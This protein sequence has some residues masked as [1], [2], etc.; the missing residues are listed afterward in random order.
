MN[1]I[2]S[3]IAAATAA[4][5][6][7]AA[8]Y[9]TA[10]A[11][12]TSQENAKTSDSARRTP[13]VRAVERIGPAVVNVHTETIVETPF[14]G[15]PGPTGDPFFDRFFHGFSPQPRA[16]KRTSLGSGV[17]VGK[18]GTLVTNEHVILRASN[19]RV[20]LSDGTEYD[21][22]LVG[23]D[24]DSDLAVL[25]VEADEDLPFAPM[26]GS[27]TVWIGETV[28]AIGNPYGLSH[29]VTTGVISAT[30]RTI[31]A[32]EFVYHDFIQ[33]D[34]SI[35]PGNSGGPLLNVDGELI[36]IN[37]AIHREGEGIGF[38]IPIHRVRSI[39]DQIVQFGTVRPPWVG[40]QV[41]NLTDEL[42]FHFG[43]EARSGVLVSGI[44]PGSPA[45]KAGLERG[46]IITHAQGERVKD[47][48]RFDQKIRSLAAGANLE[49]LVRDGDKARKLEVRVAS[50]PDD[51]IDQA[52]WQLLG[53]AFADRERGALVARIRRGSPVAEIGVEPGDI[54]AG[55]GGHEIETVDE[56]RR[57][58]A[59]L[60][61]RNSVQL[62]V[63][64]GR[65]LYRVRVPFASKF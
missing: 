56:F 61:S 38:A 46:R 29:T 32:G 63:V 5:V 44:E 20:L 12:E 48:V 33:T 37:T 30:G 2:R 6:L 27:D 23:A 10:G 62:A 31:H 54:I 39:V 35:N 22:K 3:T 65:R 21:A 59:P 43:V 1:S 15:R 55:V 14:G 28:I 45:E 16:R 47:A 18:D 11:A 40:I 41:Q 34:A 8:V 53:L 19:I 25:R 64:R 36:G 4:L 60:R 52:A 13:V 42:A 51:L 58:F 24:S 26:A 17:L 9:G 49:L 57:R 7:G 50:L